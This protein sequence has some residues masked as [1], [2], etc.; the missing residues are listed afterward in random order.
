M[1]GEGV[2]GEGGQSAFTTS[3]TSTFFKRAFASF[4]TGVK[5]THF[6]VGE[7]GG[8]AVYQGWGG[9]SMSSGAVQGWGF[10]GYLGAEGEVEQFDQPD[11][12]HHFF[13]RHLRCVSELRLW[14]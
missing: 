9:R 14:G 10:C 8:G 11:H 6:F 3:N 7:G 13:A 5:L 2:V 4:K 12:V 1:K